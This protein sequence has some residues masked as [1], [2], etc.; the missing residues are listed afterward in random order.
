MALTW[1]RC[2]SGAAGPLTENCG[3]HLGFVEG[4]MRGV[5]RCTQDWM[6]EEGA[7]R[8]ERETRSR[9]ALRATDWVSALSRPSN[10]DLARARLVPCAS[11]LIS[12]AI[13]IV[14]TMAV[15]ASRFLTTCC[16]SEFGTYCY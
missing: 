12:T 14:A 2:A 10:R 1:L 11:C 13:S 3:R 4:A 5:E 6:R 9:D 7:A 8:H 16:C 15:Y